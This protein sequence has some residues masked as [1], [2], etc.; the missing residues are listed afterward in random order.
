MVDSNANL[1]HKVPE[2]HELWNVDGHCE[3]ERWHQILPGP[4]LEGRATRAD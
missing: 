2:L 3:E 1:L 4:L